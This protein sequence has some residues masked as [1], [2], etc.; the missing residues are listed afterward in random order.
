MTTATAWHARSFSRARISLRN[1]RFLSLRGQSEHQV[2]RASCANS[3]PHARSLVRPQRDRLIVSLAFFEIRHQAS[4]AACLPDRASPAPERG[5]APS[6]NLWYLARIETSAISK[7]LSVGCCRCARSNSAIASAGAQGPIRCCSPSGDN[8]TA[9]VS[10]PPLATCSFRVCACPACPS[11]PSM[12]IFSI[13][14]PLHI[15]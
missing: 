6:Q 11:Q 7:S 8:S 14:E 15:A 5:E 3:G 10:V 2:S 9:S 1:V 13:C 4:G 12:D